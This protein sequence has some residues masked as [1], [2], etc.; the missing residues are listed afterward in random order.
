MFQLPADPYSGHLN[1]QALAYLLHGQRRRHLEG[2]LRFARK[3]GYKTAAESLEKQIAG[4]ENR[5]RE[6]I[7]AE[8]N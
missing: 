4:V 3:E 6:L 7:V 1:L 8:L 5:A 2:C